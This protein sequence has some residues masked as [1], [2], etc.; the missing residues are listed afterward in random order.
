MKHA[1]D[2]MCLDLNSDCAFSADA[3]AP[4]AVRAH[5]RTYARWLQ[6][7]SASLM[8]ARREEAEHLDHGVVRARD[9]QDGAAAG[10][11]GDLD[12]VAH[13]RRAGAALGEHAREAG[14]ADE[15]ELALARAVD[16]LEALDHGGH[17]EPRGRLDPRADER[18]DRLDRSGRLRSRV[19]HP[20]RPST[21]RS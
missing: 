16:G 10:V 2:E 9:A 13:D 15:G 21:L 17:R 1:F 19:S 12:S 11:V 7:Q 20:S 5:Y 4:A 8:R 3:T 6:G 14:V 18:C